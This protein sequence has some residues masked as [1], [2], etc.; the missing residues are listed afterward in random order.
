MAAAHRPWGNYGLAVS[1]PAVDRLALSL[2]DSCE[3][4]IDVVTRGSVGRG[5]EGRF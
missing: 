3:C 2:N 5:D 4:A 1:A